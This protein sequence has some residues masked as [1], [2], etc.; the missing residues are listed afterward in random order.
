MGKSLIEDEDGEF[1]AWKLAWIPIVIFAFWILNPIVIVNAGERGVILTWGAVED[2]IMGEGMNFRTPIAQDVKIIDVRT[3]K[4][5]VKAAAASAD[6]QDVSTTVALNYHLD[7]T[8]VN[9][10]YQTLGYDWSERVIVPAI[11][12][13]VK[14]ATAQFT[15]E[16]L[17]TKRAA[18]KQKIEDITTARLGEYGINE[19]TISITDFTFSDSF[20]IAIENK[21]TAEQN[22][23]AARNKLEQIKYEAEQKVTTATAEATAIRI[24]GEALHNNPD[25]V[26]LR[27]IERWNGVLPS[28]LAG[29]GN[30]FIFDISSLATPQTGNNGNETR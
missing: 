7:S 17:I 12:E 11:Q 23:L 27:W 2:K 28:V 13:S 19:E 30:G 3:Q 10:I 6:L 9:R 20:N 15:A 14:A 18:V 26:S 16:E 5:E 25:V 22:A 29:G 1:Q 21:V 24:Q 8:K 4:Y